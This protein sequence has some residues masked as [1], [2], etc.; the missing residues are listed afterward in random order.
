MEFKNFMQEQVMLMQ[1]QQ[2]TLTAHS[3]NYLELVY[4]VQG[5]AIHTINGMQT[6]VREGDFF[7]IDYNTEH[8]YIV[9]NETNLF[10]INCLFVP[11]L[12]DVTLKSCRSFET[13]LN[14]RL[15]HFNNSILRTNPANYIFHDEDG[16]ILSLFN[17]MLQEYAQKQHGY[18]EL[19]RCK[20][21]E[22]LI[23][24][25]RK[26][27]DEEAVLCSDATISKITSLIEQRYAE[28]I[29]LTMFSAQFNYS[30]PHLSQKFKKET[31]VSF[32]EFLQKTRIE[33]SCNLL[34]NTNDSISAIAEQVG[35]SDMKTFHSVFKKIL[36]TTPN[37]F[38]SNFK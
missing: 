26:I 18:I 35:Y 19:I 30:L 33:K 25:M 34:L 31:G 14:N 6:T 15:I 12:I 27:T 38:R 37:T 8:G 5:E 2:E 36:A 22:L 4:I 23:L 10:L 20:L 3:H 1:L 7:I 24:T 11:T 17:T 16:T 28:D 9:E 21:I 29:T 13:L 32:R